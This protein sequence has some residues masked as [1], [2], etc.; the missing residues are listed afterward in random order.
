MIDLGDKLEVIVIYHDKPNS[1]VPDKINPGV[2]R[3]ADGNDYL[4]TLQKVDDTPPTG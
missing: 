1:G 4:L 3:A 2:V